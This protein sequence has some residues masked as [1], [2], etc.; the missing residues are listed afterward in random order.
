M[1]KYLYHLLV[2]LFQ[3]QFYLNWSSQKIF[4][5]R[6]FSLFFTIFLFQAIDYTSVRGVSVVTNKGE[7]TVSSL[8]IP[9]AKM[10]DSGVYSCQNGHGIDPV[11]VHVVVSPYGESEYPTHKNLKVGINPFI[12]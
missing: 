7:T 3:A 2:L 6:Y 12:D 10:A 1:Y 11:D 5:L 8:I 9:N 4:Q